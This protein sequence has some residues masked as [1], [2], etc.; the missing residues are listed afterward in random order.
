MEHLH[1]H[2]AYEIRVYGIVQYRW[3]NLFEPE[4][5][6]FKRM[7]NDRA[8]VK[9]LIYWAYISN[10]TYNF[11]SYYF[12]PHVQCRRIRVGQNDDGGESSVKPTLLVFNHFSHAA[13]RCKD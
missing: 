4:I 13:G 10:E 1:V 11:C 9:G 12:E 7:V 2:L 5:E 3:M 6:G 8:K